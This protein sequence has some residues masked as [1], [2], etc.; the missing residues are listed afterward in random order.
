MYVLSPVLG[1]AS[2]FTI[3]NLAYQ[4]L[5]RPDWLPRLD[6]PW[7]LLRRSTAGVLGSHQLAQGRHQRRRRVTTVSPTLRARD[8]DTGVRLRVRRH[9]PPARR[10]SRRHPERHRH[11]AVG[12]CPTIRIC[13][14]RSAPAILPASGREDGPCSNTTADSRLAGTAMSRPLVGHG[15][16]DGRSE[17]LRPDRRAGRATC[18]LDASFVVLGTGEARYQDIWT[19][20]AARIPIGSALRI[21]FDEALAH[22]IEAARTCS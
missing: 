5:T 19:S 13:R 14:S 16:A 15:L 6:L 12:S 7:S 1:G 9:P 10:R 8:P 21:G 18:R 20:L 22:L 4:G 3:H 17:R 2:V 11:R